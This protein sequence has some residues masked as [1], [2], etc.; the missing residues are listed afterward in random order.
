ML[1]FA[2]CGKGGA[3]PEAVEYIGQGGTGPVVVLGDSLSEGHLISPDATWVPKVA[4]QLGKEVVNLGRGGFTTEQSIPRVKGEVLP[5]K[6]RLVVVELG[7]NDALQQIDKA[8]TKA[9]LQTIID[10]LHA[11]KIPVL[12][13]GVQG[14]I[15]SDPYED[16]F[17]DLASADHTAYI[18][19][20]L[21]GIIGDKNLLVDNFHPN[22]AGHAKIADRVAPV[23]SAL[24]AE[25]DKLRTTQEAGKS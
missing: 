7:G 4:K 8:K 10:Q 25:Q 19:N 22:E 3:K 20:I 1:A 6:P 17:N 15:N 24:L 21:E 16:M 13:M 12:L 5:L 2:G 23:L 14:G 9:N 18:T 11:E